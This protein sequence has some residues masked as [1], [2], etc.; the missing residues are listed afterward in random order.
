MS[1]SR[2]TYS[3]CFFTDGQ[4]SA[5][6]QNVFKPAIEQLKK[7]IQS[8]KDKQT[9]VTW[10]TATVPLLN[11]KSMV[12]F[13]E[14][15]FNNLTAIQLAHIVAM[16][17]PLPANKTD[18]SF[19]KDFAAQFSFG[20]RNAKKHVLKEQEYS[21]ARQYTNTQYPSITEALTVVDYGIRAYVAA[22]KIHV[23]GSEE[24]AGECDQIEKA[25]KELEKGSQVNSLIE[26]ALPTL[27]L[28]SAEVFN[29]D[30]KNSELD[31]SAGLNEVFKKRIFNSVR[32]HDDG[33]SG[34]EEHRECPLKGSFRRLLNTGFIFNTDGIIGSSDNR[35]PGALISFTSR[36]ILSRDIIRPKTLVANI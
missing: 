13:M 25:I 6:P 36:F 26:E 2:D 35:K 15:Y 24:F 4:L 32:M 5:V 33:F 23:L 7:S 12:N 9:E 18:F 29:Q 21:T 11:S 3:Y 10:R 1:E 30:E 20:V 34:Y 19:L 8:A 14:W 22:L 17:K 16:T 31:W 28:P 27:A